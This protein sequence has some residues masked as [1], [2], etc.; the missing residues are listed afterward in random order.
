M[1]SL[2][3]VPII[4][5]AFHSQI[6]VNKTCHIPLQCGR[7]SSL[8]LWVFFQTLAFTC[9]LPASF[10]YNSHMCTV[11]CVAG[12]YGI[13][14]ASNLQSVNSV[15]QSVNRVQEVLQFDWLTLLAKLLTSFNKSFKLCLSQFSHPK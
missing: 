10:S 4:L 2:L 8:K 9:L 7:F 3:F 6:I 14:A 11:L 1:A 12:V 15:S 13:L 5:L